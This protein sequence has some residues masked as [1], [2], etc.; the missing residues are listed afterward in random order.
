MAWTW[1]LHGRAYVRMCV[2]SPMEG[3]RWGLGDRLYEA[4]VG[5][6]AC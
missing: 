4:R 2:C 6:V 1:G 3:L 5:L